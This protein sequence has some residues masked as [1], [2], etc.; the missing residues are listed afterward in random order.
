MSAKEAGAFAW[1]VTGLVLA[2]APPAL[3]E[4]A[5]H[6][7]VRAGNLAEVQQLLDSGADVNEFRQGKT[8][9]HHAVLIDPNPEVVR[10][11]LD[12]G[13]RVGLNG[14][15]DMTALHFAVVDPTLMSAQTQSNANN[16]PGE[17]A[18][19]LEVIQ[20]LLDVGATTYAKNEDGLTPLH[21]AAGHYWDPEIADILLS[22]GAFVD[23]RAE[24]DATPL[25]FATAFNGNPEVTR[26]LLDAGADANAQDTGGL[27]PLHLASRFR[28]DG[29]VA[30]LLLD[31]GADVNAKDREGKTPLDYHSERENPSWPQV[32]KD[33]GGKCNTNC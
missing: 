27:T 12:A 18:W 7:A 30:Q 29:T 3:A 24:N 28:G 16:A 32:L 5:L 9:L 21:L 33:A 31:A 10:A 19:R 11:L 8:P 6:K 2:V 22:A 23:A 20:L 13:A 4:P 26:L 15:H 1:V 17:T 14:H 25:H